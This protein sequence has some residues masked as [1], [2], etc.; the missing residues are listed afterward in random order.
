MTTVHTPQDGTPAV[1]YG[2]KSTDDEQGS[3]PTQLADG[4]GLCEREGA[5]VI[6]EYS[7]NAKSAWKGNRG[8]GLAAARAHAE[9]LARKHGECMLVVQHTDRLARGD[10][11]RADHLVELALW[12]RKCGVRIRSVQDDSTGENLLMAVVMGERNHEDSRR[13]SEAVK[14]GK[15]R[16]FEKGERLGGPV[17]DGYMRLLRTV[18]SKAMA[19]YELCPQR[20]PI[21]R[22]LFE[23]AAEGMPPA[24]IARTLNAEGLRTRSGG[25]WKRR[26]VQDT[27][28]NPW[29]AGMVARG[30]S[31]PGAPVET[32]PG[33][34]P[35]LVTREAWDGIQAQFA[36][37]DKGKGS[38]RTPKGRPGSNHLLWQL[39]RCGRCRGAM[40][41]ITSSYRRKTDRQ[42]AAGGR[43]RHYRC[44][45][46][47]DHDGV[48]DAPDVDADVVEPGLIAQL[49]RYFTDLDALVAD[50]VGDR[51]DV[52]DML[53]RQV[54]TEREQ[55]V[56]LRAREDLLS[57]KYA[58]HLAA[59]QDTM[60]NADAHALE[61][62]GHE[63]AQAEHRLSQLEATV[64]GHE[65][66][67]PVNAVLDWWNELAGELR[68]V[69]KRGRLQAVN[70]GLRERLGS[71]TLNTMEDGTVLVL[72]NPREPVSL[73][74]VVSGEVPM[75][76]EVYGY[77]ARGPRELT[78]PPGLLTCG[79]EPYAHE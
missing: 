13:K 17:P 74:A 12:A 57:A 21:I 6:A 2:A 8:D 63:R 44:E 18:E 29:Y 54:T 59:G 61:R 77:M 4:R 24:T 76:R 35:K 73:S 62:T 39:A 41:T 19:Y 37:R 67:D 5:T 68:G 20:E 75:P 43:K 26:R 9:Q 11:V 3:I 58:E 66:R 55:V 15:R 72:T 36:A 1:V 34:H 56:K 16:Q 79:K 10:G 49:D 42:G 46:V 78:P 32:A 60:A 7:D 23:L 70:D 31:T 48:C 27:L 40:R 65:T 53:E 64:A 45:H 14:S 71:V 69:L 28:Q 22:R 51:D 33:S 52:R 50:A 25:T 47:H 38:D 30:R